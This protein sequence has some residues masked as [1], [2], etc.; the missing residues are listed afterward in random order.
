MK[1]RLLST[2]AVKKLFKKSGCKR[3]SRKA[4]LELQKNIEE[5]ARV[6]GKLAVKNAL[7]EGRKT[8]REND[9][10]EAIKEIEESKEL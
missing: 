5:Y 9:I 2:V 4:Y 8:V 7:Y 6:I 10:K 3:I 1:N